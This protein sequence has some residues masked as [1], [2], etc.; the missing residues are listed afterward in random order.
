MANKIRDVSHLPE[1]FDIEP[2]AHWQDKD[3]HEAAL[4]VDDRFYFWRFADSVMAV[5]P[6]RKRFLTEHDIKMVLDRLEQTAKSPYERFHMEPMAELFTAKRHTYRDRETAASLD[7]KDREE[8]AISEHARTAAKE[9]LG[10]NYYS[11]FG[12]E[13]HL[14]TLWDALN[15][16]KENAALI[17]RVEDK[18]RSLSEENGWDYEEIRDEMFAHIPIYGDDGS[19][20]VILEGH[21]TID[22][23]VQAVRRYLVAN[24][25]APG[26]MPKA[27]PSE[28]R[29]LFDYRAAAY[30]DLQ[31]WACLT[32]SEI[33]AKCMAQALFPDGRFGELDMR[34]SR[35]VGGFFHRL[36][37]EQGYLDDLVSK[38]AEL[39]TLQI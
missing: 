30:A 18:A 37:R 19:S 3:P 1:W 8:E 4:A 34:P 28:V 22:A 13:V 9:I 6:G 36:A 5:E 16:M 35:T 31:T 33:T 38:A 21:P 24:Y 12:E 26:T 32:R 17:S 20:L 39:D 14:A 2:Y 25:S 7:D 11:S 15:F 23:E 27:R 10:E 29:K